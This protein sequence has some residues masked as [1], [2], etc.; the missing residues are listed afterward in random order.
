MN[1][2][3]VVVWA[4]LVAGCHG[5]GGKKAESYDDGGV[6]DAKGRRHDCRRGPQGCEKVRPANDEFS[7]ACGKAGYRIVRCGCN[8]FCTGNPVETDEHFDKK[9]KGKD[10]APAK[11][12]CDLAESSGAFQDACTDVGGKLEQCGCEW[13][14]TR[15]LKGAVD[16]TPPPEAEPDG[17]AGTAKDKDGDSTNKD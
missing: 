9:N 17:D 14:C 3:R 7:D 10:C 5:F 4:S 12:S 15:K 2:F 8:D 1:G 16:D 11:E 6:F 13:L